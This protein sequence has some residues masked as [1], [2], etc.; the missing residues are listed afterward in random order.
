M[1]NE[2]LNEF[3]KTH[4]HLDAVYIAGEVLFIH[5]ENADAFAKD[6]TKVK[7]FTREQIETDNAA[8][9]KAADDKK[10]ADDA[11]KQK[12]ADDVAKQK[13]EDDK[14]A[15]DSDTKKT[16]DDAAKQKADDKKNK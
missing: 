4:P 12:A 1:Q 2:K 6:A 13:A 5:K 7:T 11:A 15:A 3:F 10:T 8:K 16:A 9:Q 14:K